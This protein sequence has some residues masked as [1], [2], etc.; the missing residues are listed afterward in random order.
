MDFGERL[1]VEQLARGGVVVERH[2]PHLQLRIHRDLQ[3]IGAYIDIRK[4]TVLRP[5]WVC[6]CV[7]VYIAVLINGLVNCGRPRRQIRQTSISEPRDF[8]SVSRLQTMRIRR[9]REKSGCSRI[10][11]EPFDFLAEINGK[12]LAQLFAC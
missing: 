5:M 11:N 6:V 12:A 8:S 7:C 4:H 1:A 9:P 2:L 3:I 10:G